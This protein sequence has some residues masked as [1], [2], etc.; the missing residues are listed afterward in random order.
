MTSKTAPNDDTAQA[1]VYN[2][3]TKHS[4]RSLRTN[5]HYLDWQNQPLTLKIYPSLEP[6]PLPQDWAQTGISALSAISA[7]PVEGNR[8][9]IPSLQDL[10]RILY[11][12]AGITKKKTYT[13]GEM[14]FRAASCTG[15]LYEFEIYLVCGDLP[16]LKAGV[17]HFAPG[18]FALRLL[19]SGDYRGT[20]LH[21]VAG[22]TSVAH[23][24][25]TMICAGTYWRNAWKYRARTYRHFGWDNGTILANMF[26]MTAALQV[27]A[28]LV[29]GWIDSEVNRLLGLDTRHE[30]AFSAVSLGHMAMEPPAAPMELPELSFP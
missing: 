13:G 15:A 21:A 23:A 5:P 20:L 7:G 19:R 16:D 11:F 8:E 27:P 24:P 29:L 6:I 3:A 9:T 12:S 10:A 28:K 17:Y 30:V 4:E 25:L 14:Y 22:E 2:N 26:A 18:D 1:W